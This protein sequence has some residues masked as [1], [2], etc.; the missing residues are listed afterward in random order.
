[1][2]IGIPKIRYP[3]IS[4]ATMEKIKKKYKKV[5]HY[6]HLTLDDP[7]VKAEVEA[8]ADAKAQEKAQAL[9]RARQTWKDLRETLFRNRFLFLSGPIT[10]ARSKKL[11]SLLAFYE[12]QDI[13]KDRKEVAKEVSLFIN[14]LGGDQR[15]GLGIFDMIQT[16]K[17]DVKTR[18]IGMAC[19]IASLILAGGKIT[20]RTASSNSLIGISQDFRFLDPKLS[21]EVD[22][23]LDKFLQLYYQ[24]IMGYATST[25]LNPLTIKEQI[26]NGKL[27]SPKEAKIHGIIDNILRTD[28]FYY[29]ALVKYA[30]FKPKKSKN[31]TVDQGFIDYI[32]EC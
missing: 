5:I 26:K 21:N 13:Y 14:S 4:R 12:I 9:V 22:Q 1:M 8:Q 2:P 25:M 32:N 28:N 6:S 11:I 18:N 23:D 24:V 29:N 27:L 17:T 10:K 15:G 3:I 16:I 19:S 7:K 31:I 20:R 30:I